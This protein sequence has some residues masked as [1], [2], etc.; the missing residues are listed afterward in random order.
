MIKLYIV[1][2]EKKTQV[3]NQLA[4]N[5]S[6]YRVVAEYLRDYEFRE[7]NWH[8]VDIWTLAKES[9]VELYSKKYPYLEAKD[10]FHEVAL[11]IKEVIPDINEKQDAKEVFDKWFS[12]VLLA[13]YTITYAKESI[14]ETNS[15]YS[16]A[17]QIRDIIKTLCKNLYGLEY[18]IDSAID[19]GVITDDYDYVNN[20]SRKKV[21]ASSAST[22]DLMLQTT[23]IAGNK[24]IESNDTI[25]TEEIDETPIVSNPHDKVRLELLCKLFENSGAS[26]KERG[27]KAELAR[28]AA[29][30]TGLSVGTC[31]NYM[32]NRDLNT[33]KH[34]EEVL[35]VN[36]QLKKVGID[37][38]L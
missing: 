29:F 12:G 35:I 20:C 7:Y 31:K 15:V 38:L 26:T 22:I 27:Q 13:M 33:S 2:K 34:S 32:T 21:N 5:E 11:V 10:F 37:I 25:Q 28:L 3:L 23:E 4:D 8:R 24:E 6:L 9:L 18:T 16:I 19:D 1:E 30:I 14:E 36:S 17:D